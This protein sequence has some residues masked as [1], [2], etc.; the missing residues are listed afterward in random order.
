[1][2]RE[3]GLGNVWQ[4][5]LLV[6]CLGLG[7]FARQTSVALVL[8]CLIYVLI[9]N[10]VKSLT[11]VSLLITLFYSVKSTP[12]IFSGHGNQV[13][14]YLPVHQLFIGVGAYPNPF[15]IKPVSDNVGLDKYNQITNRNFNA[16]PLELDWPSN[17]S[18]REDYDK[19]LLKEIKVMFNEHPFIYFRN[20]ILNFLVGYSIGYTDA[21]P[22][23]LKLIISLFGLV[24]ACYLL[25]YRLYIDVL[26]IAL[27]HVIFSPYFTPIPVFMFS[28]YILLIYALQKS[29]QLIR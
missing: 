25:Y 4:K 21:F 28:T 23:W 12:F 20:A 5:L 10:K 16:S 6:V 2:I 26:V 14:S 8:F 27:S 24:F 17:L 9:K 11:F 15:G 22:Y 18:L 19:V 3:K 13:G 1:M 29:L 7:F